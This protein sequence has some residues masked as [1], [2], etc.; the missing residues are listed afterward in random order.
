MLKTGT[1]TVGL[2]CKD[3][4]ILGSDKRAT[5]GYLI[6]DKKAKKI[7]QIDR[8]LALTI[9][10]S[11]SDA[12][13]LIKLIKAEIKLFSLRCQREPLVS[14]VANLLGAIVYYKIRSFSAI[15]S[16]THFVLGGKDSKGYSLYDLYPDG[17]VSEHNNF[18]SS[19]SGSVFAYGMLENEYKEGLLLKDGIRLVYK[20]LYGALNRDIG[21]GNGIEIVSVSESGFKAEIDKTFSIEKQD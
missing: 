17:S 14:E 16:I 21:S 19:G 10:G 9:A 7:H 3:G 15:P 8:N 5:A 1:T 11:V 2:I 6:A 12:Q 18:I 20:A 4:V 13:L